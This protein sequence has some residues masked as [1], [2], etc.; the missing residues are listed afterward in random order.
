MKGMEMARKSNGIIFFGIILMMF[1][2]IGVS[3][4]DSEGRLVKIGRGKT[5]I[6]Y[7]VT[8]RDQ[9][10]FVVNNHGLVILD[11]KDPARPN[12]IGSIKNLEPSFAVALSGAYAFIG[13]EGGLAVIEVSD[14]KSSRLIGRFLADETVNVLSISGDKAFLINSGNTIKIQSIANPE[15][16]QVI[17]EFNDGGKYYYKSLEIRDD[18]LFLAD[19]VQGLELI[20]VSDPYLP[21][22]IQTLPGTK[23]IAAVFIDQKVLALDFYE[24]GPVL[25]DISDPRSLARY[26]GEFSKAK[27]L[28]VKGMGS[29]Y[30]VIKSDDKSISVINI[31]D[32]GN[33]ILV[34]KGDLQK[35]TA[36]HG[37]FIKEKL[38]Y[39]T[40]MKGMIVFEIQ[41]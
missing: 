3:H 4:T 7:N 17:S 16:P 29:A 11:V 19:I 31:S 27:N 33:P 13:G 12:K 10:A 36:V 41:E 37:T 2:I 24:K 38:I 1:S 6:S 39:F 8:V 15:R 22:K 14:P 5:G 26:E 18:I 28:R 30:L 25:Y 35:K 9:T 20:D 34:A 23:G 40:G 32:P 21:R